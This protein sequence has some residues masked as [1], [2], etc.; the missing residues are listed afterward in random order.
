MENIPDICAKLF[1]RA[2]YTELKIT[3]AIENE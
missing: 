2:L 1:R 3:T